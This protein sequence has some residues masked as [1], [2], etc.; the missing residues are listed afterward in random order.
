MV[1]NVSVNGSVIT[2][3][4][5]DG[6]SDTLD[7]KGDVEE[8][9]LKIVDGVLQ[10]VTDGSGTSG[11]TLPVTELPEYTINLEGNVLTLL[12]NGT[13]A[14]QVTLPETDDSG[15]V[16]DLPTAADF[17]VED[18]Y[19]CYKGDP[20]GVYLLGSDAT[21]SELK[22]VAEDG[23]YVIYQDGVAIDGFIP[24]VEIVDGKLTVMGEELDINALLPQDASVVI[25]Q[26]D[27]EGNVVGASIKVGDETITLPIARA[28]EGLIFVPNL[29]VEGVGTV[30]YNTIKLDN[31][32]E[33][34]N[35]Q[36][37]TFRT[38]PSS[39]NISGI[40]WTFLNR[41]VEFGTRAEVEGE[42]ITIIGDVTQNTTPYSS[43][44]I[45]TKGNIG[46]S[47]ADASKNKYDVV[48]LKAT[49]AGKSNIDGD[50]V[51]D[52]VQVLF[53]TYH[54]VEIA[55]KQKMDNNAAIGTYVFTNLKT[56]YEPTS[57]APD[58]TVSEYT[59]V[60]GKRTFDLKNYVLAVLDKNDNYATPA[61]GTN[62]QWDLVELD[63]LGF[64]DYTWTFESVEYIPAGSNGT[65]QQDYVAL[66]GSVVTVLTEYSSIDRTPVFKA[67]LYTKAG[68][69]MTSHFIK[70]KLDNSVVTEPAPH[71]INLDPINYLDL[72]SGAWFSSNN[73][74][75]WWEV[76]EA[77][78]EELGMSHDQFVEHYITN[79]TQ[80]I[81]WTNENTTK[82]PDARYYPYNIPT[83]A[84]KGEVRLNV[85]TSGSTSTTLLEVSVNPETCFGDH[86]WVVVLSSS[87]TNR[88]VKIAVNFTLTAPTHPAFERSYVDVNGDVATV[89]GQMKNGTFTFDAVMAESFNVT[90]WKD[91][92]DN[93]APYATYNVMSYNDNN[94]GTDFTSAAIG[95]SA[96]TGTIS[97]TGDHNTQEITTSKINVAER[98]Y[99]VVFRSEFEN[100]GR[101]ETPWVYRFVNPLYVELKDFSLNTYIN[102]DPDEQEI[103]KLLTVTVLKDPIYTNGA[104]DNSN[105]TKYGI[106]GESW[107]IN[108]NNS[109]VATDDKLYFDN[110][111]SPTEV[112]WN[113]DGTRLLQK[114]TD[115]KLEVTVDTDYA[116]ATQIA[117]ITLLPTE[118]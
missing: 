40:D 53:H 103:Y 42:L 62:S 31:G 96:L 24:M 75:E 44:S 84:D 32:V 3:S 22:I 109:G 68:E 76:N 54:N 35:S 49:A 83:L 48:N 85:G 45:E 1:A 87:T 50:V 21:A 15:S 4:Y 99:N 102:G 97:N 51:S 86:T 92:N 98:R 113:N 30:K 59:V 11:V 28:L 118:E 16:I 19:L 110:I 65:N 112:I 95:E 47:Q 66:E 117:T 13:P 57:Y 17:T 74:K 9:S 115:A 104:K 101:L 108:Y 5:T 56:Q 89:N 43:I 107:S 8:Y 36:T 39:A 71:S 70:F 61:Y 26:L 27:D 25:Y 77:I 20:T 58:F 37:L 114:N 12:K 82:A 78:Y 93:V 111:L 34:S 7:T 46:S 72:Y 6:S 14:G 23:K 18:G 29:Y 105:Y 52:D 41:A 10:L 106:N 60:N 2:V 73:E 67:S 80:A 63:E 55:N 38:N 88:E 64:S 81:D 69:F 79:G 100:K 90:S 116:T 91:F 94:G 33:L